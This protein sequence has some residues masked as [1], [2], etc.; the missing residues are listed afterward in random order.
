[1]QEAA[2]AKIEFPWFLVGFLLMSLIGSYVLGRFVV[3]PASSMALIANGTTFVLTMAMVGLGLNVNV[4]A[5]RA[6]AARPLLVIVLTST[7]LSI[8]TYWMVV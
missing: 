7:L 1:E 6:K 8:V 2:Q 4:R 3:V 5:L